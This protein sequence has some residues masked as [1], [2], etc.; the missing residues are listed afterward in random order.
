M[1]VLSRLLYGT[2]MRLIE[3]MRLC[4][5]D[6]DFYRSSGVE[7]M[8]HVYEGR[9]QRA[10]KKAVAQ[11]YICKPVSVYT[12]R[13]SFATLLFR[14]SYCAKAARAFGCKH[15][16]D[17][18]PC[19]QRRSGWVYQSAMSWPRIYHRPEWRF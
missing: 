16:H 8:H 19:T 10:R 14:Y 3:G 6:V 4:V 12:L 11:V 17:L 13:H 5:K 1:A 15:N 7:R 18:H 9:L 2:G